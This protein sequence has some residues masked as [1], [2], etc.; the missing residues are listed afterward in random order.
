MEL[1]G[2]GNRRAYSGIWNQ[3]AAAIPCHMGCRCP[4]V[5]ND[6]MGHANGDELL[7]MMGEERSDKVSIRRQNEVC[8]GLPSVRR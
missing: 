8:P 7:M 1:T 4:A 3:V 5:V 2:L 6:N